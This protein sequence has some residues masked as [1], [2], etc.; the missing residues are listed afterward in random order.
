MSQRAENSVL[1]RLLRTKTT[2]SELSQMSIAKA[3]RWSFARA[4]DAVLDTATLVSNFA[5]SDVIPE[6]M[7]TDLPSPAMILKLHGPSEDVGVAYICMQVVG[8]VIE[9]QTIGQILSMP[10]ADRH[11]TQTDAALIAGFLGSVLTSFGNLAQECD[12]RPPF[13]GFRVGALLQDARAAQMTLEDA[14]HIKLSISLDFAIGAKTGVIHLI[15]PAER[16]ADKQGMQNDEHWRGTLENSVLGTSVWL[17]AVLCKLNLPL[18]KI[19]ELAK[20]DV[21]C[22]TGASV[23]GVTLVGSDGSTVMKARLGRSGQVRAVRINL[24][25]SSLSAAQ[26]LH[27][28]SPATRLTSPQSDE[29]VLKIKPDAAVDIDTAVDLPSNV[30]TAETESVPAPAAPNPHL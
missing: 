20:D 16:K 10:A 17:G 4:G 3:L 9:A 29:P 28:K 12:P 15:L 26:K 24:S 2:D 8:A 1:H 30:Q 11:P 19:G 25:T 6:N 14:K 21:I 22:L 18:S 23:D 13:D 5:E 27:D 7:N